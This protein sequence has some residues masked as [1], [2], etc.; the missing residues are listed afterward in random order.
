MA[1]AAAIGSATH[2]NRALKDFQHNC[3]HIFLER[4]QKSS[5]GACEFAGGGWVFWCWVFGY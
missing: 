4:F 1:A 5:G 3:Q 2:L